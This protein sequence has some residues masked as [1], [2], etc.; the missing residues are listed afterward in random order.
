MVQV[1][2]DAGW[3]LPATSD[4]AALKPYL[5]K[6][7]PANRQAVFDSLKHIAIAPQ[8]GANGQ[9]IQ[10]AVNNALGEIAA[11]RAKTDTAIPALATQVDGLIK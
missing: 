1:R 5:E 4:D 10:D 8:L 7:P 6:T 9:Q 3:E 11:G 2:L